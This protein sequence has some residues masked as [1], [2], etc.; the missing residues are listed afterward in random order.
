MGKCYLHI[1]KHRGAAP[2]EWDSSEHN[3]VHRNSRKSPDD[4]STTNCRGNWGRSNSVL[5]GDA[6]VGFPH[7]AERPRRRLVLTEVQALV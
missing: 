5:T 7:L 6:V 2:P 4:G 1:T 3:E